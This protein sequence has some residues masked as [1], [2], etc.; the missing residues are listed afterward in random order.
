MLDIFEFFNKNKLLRS[1]G[2]NRSN[3]IIAKPIKVVYQIRSARNLYFYDTY[4]HV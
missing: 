1:Y 2:S 3:E 4:S